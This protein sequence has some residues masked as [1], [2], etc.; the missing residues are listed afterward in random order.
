[1]RWSAG[2]VIGCSC[3]IFTESSTSSQ[4][5]V[6]VVQFSYSLNGKSLGIAFDSHSN[7][8]LATLLRC[9]PSGEIGLYPAFTLEQGESLI[10]NIGQRAFK[11]D[12]LTSFLPL[13]PVPSS[14][15][16]EQEGV[17]VLTRSIFEVY[18][19]ERDRLTLTVTATGTQSPSSDNENILLRELQL[20]EERKLF[21]QCWLESQSL[22]PPPLPSPSETTS[23]TAVDSSPS[24]AP[25]AI[26]SS[27][28]LIAK[29]FE[30][31]GLD[32]L[33]HELMRR[34]LK[35]GGTLSERAERLFAVRGVPKKKIDK[36]LKAKK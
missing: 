2:D 10:L 16:S 22:N 29:D 28:Y 11:Y 18:Q 19:S 3:D 14:S 13:S 30:I 8:S 1:V 25:I 27:E 15:S 31:F 6:P 7:L 4:P 9:V 24:F 12:P 35:T 26:E 34:G 32:H 36:R 5:T 33:K 21:R 17:V 20:S 23:A